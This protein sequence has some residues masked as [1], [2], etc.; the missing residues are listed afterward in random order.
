MAIQYRPHTTSFQ[1]LY[2]LVALFLTGAVASYLTLDVNARRVTSL[3][4]L[5]A[6]CLLAGI[7]STWSA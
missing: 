7:T 6:I 5:P 3:V 1:R 4:W 2:P